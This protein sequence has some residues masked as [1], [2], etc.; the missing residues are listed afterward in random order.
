MRNISRRYIYWPF[1]IVCCVYTI[2]AY[3][4]FC[5]MRPCR[6]VYGSNVSEEL[7]SSIFRVVLPRRRRRLFPP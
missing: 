5:L 3:E 4:D 2:N 7:S 6:L 1:A